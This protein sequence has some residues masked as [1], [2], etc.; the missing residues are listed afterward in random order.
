IQYA[1]DRGVL[2]RDLKPGNIMLGKYGETL[3]VDWGLAKPIGKT[4]DHPSGA[5]SSDEPELQPHS[6]SGTA[7]TIQGSAIGTPQYMS[8]EQA[9]GRLDKLGPASD[10]YSLGATL[11]CVLTGQAP[12][13]DIAADSEKKLDVAAM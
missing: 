13:G 1:H 4:G 7:E 8:P 11:F 5:A 2:H 9:A 10:I 12:I 3:V 6:M